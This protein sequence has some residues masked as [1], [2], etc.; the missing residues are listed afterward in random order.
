MI[1]IRR[2]RGVNHDYNEINIAFFKSLCPV[3]GDKPRRL[4]ITI[5]SEEPLVIIVRKVCHDEFI[6]AINKNLPNDLQL[7]I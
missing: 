3:C 2:N 1:E 6:S 7:K 4:F 5:E